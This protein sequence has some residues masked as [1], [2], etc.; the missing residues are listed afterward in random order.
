MRVLFISDRY[1]PH[2]DGGYE[3]ACHA[4]AERMRERG[5]DVRVLTS[6]YRIGRE[7]EEG[8]VHRTLHRYQDSPNLLELALWEQRD[9]YRLR[10]VLR[11]WAPD[12]IYAWSMAQL[13]PSLHRVLGT[14]GVP[15]VYAIQ[16]VWI[17][18]QLAWGDS[19]RGLWCRPGSSL[20]KRLSKA[21]VRTCIG[22]WDPLWLNP[23]RLED[24]HL[25]HVFFCSHY[26]QRRHVEAQL[27]LGDWRVIYNGIDLSR[28]HP[29]QTAEPRDGLR[30][31]F[32]GRLV[33]E[34]G[35]HLAIAAV[36]ELRRQG[37][38][39]I[40]LDVAGIP[41]FPQRYHDGL[42]DAVAEAQLGNHVRFLGA[43]PNAELP[44]VYRTHDALLFPSSHLEGLPVTILEAMACGVVV[45][46][47]T[48]G[49]TA[50][51]LEDG[52]N[53]LAVPPPGDAAALA[54]RVVHLIRNPLRLQTLAAAALSW[55]RQHCDIDAIVTQTE[56]S[57]RYVIASHRRR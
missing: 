5:H 32:V 19:F 41:C 53:G 36:R 34:K 49:G 4:V 48:S 26:Q 52:K 46:A 44:G 11:D 3:I 28:F 31:L 33:K 14:S 39:D 17:P 16:D 40:R 20:V 29:R 35:A 8:H 12:V 2:Y 25:D 13:F 22:R 23:V 24:V 9:R 38:S 15:L 55:V 27:P 42:Q 6:T 21:A 1:P 18:T 45:V 50:E 7:R 56:D 57:L 37:Y 51:L 30:L 47:T 10:S 43:V 54:E